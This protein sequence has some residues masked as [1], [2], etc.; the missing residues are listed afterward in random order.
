MSLWKTLGIL[1]TGWSAWVLRS[2]YYHLVAVHRGEEER[3][4][5]EWKKEGRE[6]EREQAGL[7]PRVA[8]DEE[9]ALCLPKGLFALFLKR[10]LFASCV[11]NESLT[12][13]MTRSAW[14]DCSTRIEALC[15]GRSLCSNDHPPVA[16]PSGPESAGSLVQSVQLE[17]CAQSKHHSLSPESIRERRGLL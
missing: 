17:L 11:T 5:E 8:A 13:L 12:A 10:L 4:Q 3:W 1:G 15:S 14:S 2:L 9:T 7:Q 6:G 16:K